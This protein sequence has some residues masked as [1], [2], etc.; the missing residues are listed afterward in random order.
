MNNL[1][2]VWVKG[3]PLAAELRRPIE[4]VSLE[5]DHG[6]PMVITLWRSDGTGLR[7]Y[8]QMHDVA[9]R[10]EVGALNFDLVLA[11]RPEET[12]ADLASAFQGEIVVSKLIIH[13]SGTSAESGVI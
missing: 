9:V 13:E 3:T 7:V 5:F 1:S 6:R 10:R 2:F 12:I 4:Q 11:P 8:S